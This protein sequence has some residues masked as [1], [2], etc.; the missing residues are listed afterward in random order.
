MNILLRDKKTKLRGFITFVCIAF[1]LN[2]FFLSMYGNEIIKTSKS[3]SESKER[4][5]FQGTYSP[6]QQEVMIKNKMI[7][8]P[9]IWYEQSW[10]KR[11]KNVFWEEEF[12]STG[13]TFTVPSSSRMRDL[14]YQ[15]KLAP[16]TSYAGDKLYVYDHVGWQFSLDRAPDTIHF[17][18]QAQRDST[19]LEVFKAA[20][21][22][23]IKD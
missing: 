15:Y 8:V 2:Y 4:G 1:I 7:K 6:L 9:Q 19:W 10:G 17:T 16:S 12:L 3:I 18:I 13:F 14:N 23:F 5:H 20:T 22:S 11:Q 21:L